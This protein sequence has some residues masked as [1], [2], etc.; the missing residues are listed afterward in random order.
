[1]RTFLNVKY[2]F[3]CA[4]RDLGHE[5]PHTIA[6]GKLADA[7]K[8]GG[9][10]DEEADR[11]AKLLYNDG[12]KALPEEDEEPSDNADETGF[13]PYCGAYTFDC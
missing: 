10:A 13:D 12:R 11:I 8:A 5:D 7:N 1:M 9:L 6:I 2:Y 3:R 4:C